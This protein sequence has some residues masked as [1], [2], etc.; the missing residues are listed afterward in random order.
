MALVEASSSSSDSDRDQFK[1]L[2]DDALC[3]IEILLDKIQAKE[4][5]LTADSTSDQS[6]KHISSDDKSTIAEA[7][8]K[9][10]RKAVGDEQSSA[11]LSQALMECDPI[12]ALLESILLGAQPTESSDCKERTELSNVTE[13]INALEDFCKVVPASDMKEAL[14]QLPNL[15]HVLRT[16]YSIAS[17]L[18]FCELILN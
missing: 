16:F 2:V 17:D 10:A 4:A 15:S 6:S 8:Q 18:F 9:G 1:R 7:L 5:K 11:E 12:V 14:N 3:S 13:S